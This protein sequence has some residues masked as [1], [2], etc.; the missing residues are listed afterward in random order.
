MAKIPVKIVGANEG[1]GGMTDR[2]FFRAGEVVQWVKGVH[3]QP[4][5]ITQAEYDALTGGGSI[6]VTANLAAHF[7]LN[8]GITS[9]GGAVSQWADQ[10]GNGR[11]LKQATATNQPALQGDG[12]I[13]FD[14]VDNFLKCDAFTL[15]QPETIYLLGKQV[16]YAGSDRVCDGNTAASGAI[17]Q[18]GVSPQIQ[19]TAGA[20]AATNGNWTLDT[21]FAL[22]AVFNGASSVIHVNGSTATTGDPGAAN[23]GGFALGCAGNSANFANIQVKEVAIYSV[24]HDATTRQQV[25]NYLSGL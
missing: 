14:G 2:R 3:H 23:M 17:F 16:T 20:G 24:A 18:S 22:A 21:Y 9:N 13:L 12:S 4:L 6:P 1:Y 11:H 15:N 5:P 19:I 8:T 10:S 7:K 25:F